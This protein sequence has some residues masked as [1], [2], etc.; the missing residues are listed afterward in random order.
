MC[1][2]ACLQCSDGSRI[3]QI[4]GGANLKGRECQHKIY[5]LADFSL[6]LHENDNFFSQFTFNYRCG[7]FCRV[8]IGPRGRARGGVPG[9]GGR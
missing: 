9:V 1:V 6:K 8:N 5:Y 2:P 7:I 4:G 3:S